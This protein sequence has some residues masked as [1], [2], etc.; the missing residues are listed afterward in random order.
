MLGA[1][2]AALTT[3]VAA[4]RFPT[5]DREPIVTSLSEFVD[6]RI[7]VCGLEELPTHAELGVTHVLSILDAGWPEPAVFG[8]F[9]EHERLSMRFDD[10]IEETPGKVVVQRE[11]I[12]RLLRFGRDLAEEDGAHLLVHCHM[13][14][15]RSTAAMTLILAQARPDRPGAEALA[16][17]RRIRDKVWPNLRMIELGDEMLGRQ[18]ELVVAAEERYAHVLSRVPA[19]GPAMT[20]LGRRREVE[21][22]LARQQGRR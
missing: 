21:R 22:G 18:G 4:T 2:E 6:F 9:G 3:R 8:A 15:S 13:G 7:T 1:R 17:V 5:N 12:E 11:D 14:V 19:M 20:E 10:I 16:E